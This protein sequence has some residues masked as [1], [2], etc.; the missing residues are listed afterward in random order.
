MESLIMNTNIELVKELYNAFS[1]RN[2]NALLE[3]L[4]E[5]IEWGEPENPFNP[6]GGTRRGHNGFIE[7]LN[8]GKDA[9]DILVLEPKKFLCDFDSVAVLGYM[10][11]KAKTTGKIYESDFVH[12]VVIKGGKIVKFQEFF[13]TYL[14]GEAFR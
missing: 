5:D 1:K 13:D 12:F 11:C 2:I 6:A 14:A 10:K 9:E 7:W 3:L 8:I 4:S